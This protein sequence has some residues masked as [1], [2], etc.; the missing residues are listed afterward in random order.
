MFRLPRVMPDRASEGGWMEPGDSSTLTDI[1]P[2]D[3]KNIFHEEC[4][5]P[6][7]HASEAGPFENLF[8]HPLCPTLRSRTVGASRREGQVDE[9][10]EPLRPPSGGEQTGGFG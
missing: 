4:G 6:K 3:Q 1:P 10:L 2:V 7:M 5:D 8:G 9:A